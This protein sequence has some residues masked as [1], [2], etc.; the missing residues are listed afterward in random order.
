MRDFVVK[1]LVKL[2]LYKQ[3]VAYINRVK[4]YFQ[5]RKIRKYGVETVFEV[6]AAC[7]EAGIIAFPTFG[8][9]LGAIRDKGFIPYDYDIDMAIMYSQ[10]SEK[11]HQSMKNHGFVL[12]KQIYIKS[13]DNLIT[14]ETYSRK[15]IGVDI[16]FYFEEGNDVYIY[17]PRHHEYKEWKDANATDG[18]P[19]ARSYVPKSEFE[20]IDFLGI[21]I[22]VPVKAHEWL[23][24]IYSDSYMTPIK[25]WEAKDYKTRI[26]PT[27]ERCYRRYI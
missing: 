3:A 14:E 2:G 27:K 16:Y 23:K 8:T 20:K 22:N 17:S 11:L 18:F 4:E 24:D 12:K 21:N 9:L 25:S 7:R 1:I 19:V 15:G 26:I 13:R 6:D 5:A 10:Y